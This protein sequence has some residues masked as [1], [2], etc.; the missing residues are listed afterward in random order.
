MP[1]HWYHRFLGKIR[2][3]TVR[4]GMVFGGLLGLSLAATFFLTTLRDNIVFFRSPSEIIVAPPSERFRIGG[5]V[6]RDSLSYEGVWV[7]FVVTDFT[8]DVPVRYRGILPDLF[9]EGRGVVAEGR[10]RSDGVFVAD[11]VFAKHDETYMPP[12]AAKALEKNWKPLP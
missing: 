8:A 5:L 4:L 9:R 10:L 3:R 2:P 7:R 1:V 12:E 6:G 11:T